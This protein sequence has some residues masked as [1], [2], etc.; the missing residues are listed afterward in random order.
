MRVH[1]LRLLLE[2]LEGHRLSMALSQTAHKIHNFFM[3]IEIVHAKFGSCCIRELLIAWVDVA[4]G[5]PITACAI[6]AYLARASSAIHVHHDDASRLMDF[7][8][9][10]FQ[11]KWRRHKPKSK[12][13]EARLVIR[14]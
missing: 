9:P 2:G 4:G 10:S 14:W 11:I 13:L 8:T 7:L 3:Q 1:E 12:N 6:A 5:N